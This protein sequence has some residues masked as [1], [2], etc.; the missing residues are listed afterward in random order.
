MR[1]DGARGE[2]GRGKQNV[3]STWGRLDWVVFISVVHTWVAVF[4]CKL[5]DREGS[6]GLPQLFGI[7]KVWVGEWGPMHDC[8]FCFVHDPDN[9]T[10]TVG[11]RYQCTRLERVFLFDYPTLGKGF[12]LFRSVC[13]DRSSGRKRQYVAWLTKSISALVSAIYWPT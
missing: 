4:I 8:P 11:T 7:R 13:T 12:D 10:C 9:F 6:Q 2:E 1:L 3:S 5:I